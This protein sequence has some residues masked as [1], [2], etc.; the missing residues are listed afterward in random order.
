MCFS[1]FLSTQRKKNVF[2]VLYFEH[3]VTRKKKTHV[4]IPFE[5]LGEFFTDAGKPIRV[6]LSRITVVYALL[7]AFGAVLFLQ[8]MLDLVGTDVDPFAPIA[9][10]IGAMFLLGS[11]LMISVMLE[12]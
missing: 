3:M 12:S 11:A 9:M 4:Q 2:S 6:V 5:I 7:G 1:F 8:G 10:T